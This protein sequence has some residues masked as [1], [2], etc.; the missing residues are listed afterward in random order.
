MGQGNYDQW[1]LNTPVY[2]IKRLNA[3]Y[4]NGK[5]IEL[6]RKA[7]SKKILDIGCGNGNRIFDYLTENNIDFVGIEKFERL[8]ENS[9]YKDKII[10]ADILDVTSV[11]FDERLKNID[12]VTILGGSLYGIFGLDNHKA[13]WKNIKSFLLHEGKVIFDTPLIQGF[14][15]NDEIGEIMLIPGVT[16]LQF[17]LSEKQLKEIWK[18]NLF[19]IEEMTDFIIPGPFRI[20]YYLLNSNK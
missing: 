15:T 13:A 16:P 17:F 9:N 11:N 10:I 14:D 5:E 20:R 4:I 7:N 12:T 3:P 2:E 18:E 1:S 8:T 6:I 19:K